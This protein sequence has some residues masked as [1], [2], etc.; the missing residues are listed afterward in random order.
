MKTLTKVERNKILIMI[1]IINKYAITKETKPCVVNETYHF[2]KEQTIVFI[3]VIFSER[4]AWG[5]TFLGYVIVEAKVLDIT[6]HF[7]NIEILK[8]RPFS[9]FDESDKLPKIGNQ[10]RRKKMSLTKYYA[11]V[12]QEFSF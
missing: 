8:V 10:F 11:V 12:L 6:S 2:E 7:I 9:T 1:D 5:A 4:K 3:D